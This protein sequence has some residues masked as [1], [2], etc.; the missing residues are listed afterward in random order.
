MRSAHVMLK[1]KTNVWYSS[2]NRECLDFLTHKLVLVDE[3]CLV[4]PPYR[5]LTTSVILWMVHVLLIIVCL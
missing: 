5:L 2:W 3:P 1:H 4:A